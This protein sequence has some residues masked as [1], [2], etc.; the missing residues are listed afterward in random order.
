MKVDITCPDC[1]KLRKIDSWNLPF[2]KSHRCYVCSRKYAVNHLPIPLKGKDNPN[3]KGG[4]LTRDGYWEIVIPEYHPRIKMA[5]KE[6]HSLREHR[7]VMANHLGRDLESWE[8]VHHKNGD[9]LDNRIENLE[10][11]NQNNHIVTIL[12]TKEINS[13]KKR[14]EEL[15]SEVAQ[16]KEKLNY[17]YDS[18][19]YNQMNVMNSDRTY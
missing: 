7:L 12:Y 14:V 2:R 19:Y 6:R 5:H 18:L 10:L 11:M 4:Y 8:V 15:E 3:W 1:G 13:L 17:P 9:K 16:L